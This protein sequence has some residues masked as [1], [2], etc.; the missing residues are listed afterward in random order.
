MPPLTEQEKRELID[1]ISKKVVAE[2]KKE[3]ATPKFA[4]WA[5]NQVQRSYEINNNDGNTGYC[6]GGY[7]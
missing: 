2:L 1:E 7:M 6:F 3:W 5:N 4:T